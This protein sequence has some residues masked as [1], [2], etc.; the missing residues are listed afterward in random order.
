MVYKVTSLKFI[1]RIIYIVYIYSEIFKRGWSPSLIFTHGLK[2]LPQVWIL[3]L[4]VQDF[5]HFSEFF[6]NFVLIQL[7]NMPAS[8]QK[9]EPSCSEVRLLQMGMGW[10][11]ATGPSFHSFFSILFSSRS[12]I[13]TKCSYRFLKGCG[14]WFQ[15]QIALDGNEVD[16]QQVQVFTCFSQFFFYLVVLMQLHN[17][18]TSF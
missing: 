16:Q 6:F 17:M 10:T 14:Q 11:I 18:S 3:V 12:N 15:S 13:A 8:F 5:T 4:Q 2:Y 9:P 1:F 7:Q